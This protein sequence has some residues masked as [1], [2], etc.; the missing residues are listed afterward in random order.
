M[1]TKEIE[2]MLGTTKQT[3]IY[4]EKEGMIHPKRDEN[5]YRNYT[6]KDIDIIK[7]ILLLRSMDISIDDIK[8]VLNNQLSIREALN[9]KKENIKHSKTELDEIDKKIQNYIK[10]RKVKISFNDQKLENWSIQDTLYLYNNFIKYNDIII[11]KK[12]IQK[13]DL[14]MFSILTFG[15]R[16]MPCYIFYVDL[17]IHTTLDTYSFSI[18][19]NKDINRVFN[20]FKDTTIND[21]LNL[22]KLYNEYPDDYTREHYLG[23]HFKEWAKAYNL[24]NPRENHYISVR[25]PEC[26]NI[27]KKNITVLG[28]FKE[29][30]KDITNFIHKQKNN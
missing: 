21:P 24:D 25:K 29:L 1:K 11:E 2:R 22:I 17:D 23:I 10:R 6:Q 12:N 15:T 9:N 14:S 7:L 16:T 26:T 19:S 5:N 18:M 4:Y 27:H 20:Y 28:Q 13:I 8:F 30:G 3:L